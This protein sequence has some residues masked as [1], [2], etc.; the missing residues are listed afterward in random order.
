[1]DIICETILARYEIA[2]GQI[3]IYA[4]G[5]KWVQIIFKSI[6]FNFQPI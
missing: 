6:L 5:C 3:V 4:K 2:D 1:M